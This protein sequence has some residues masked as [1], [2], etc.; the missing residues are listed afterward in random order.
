MTLIWLVVWLVKR[1]PKVEMFRS[2]NKWG[3]ALGVCAVIDFM[4]VLGNAGSRHRPAKMKPS[5]NQTPLPD[6]SGPSD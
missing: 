6:P 2:W 3:V 4:S 5:A 1:M